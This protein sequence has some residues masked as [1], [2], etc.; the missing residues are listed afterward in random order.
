M[1]RR[2]DV[3]FIAFLVFSTVVLAE[4]RTITAEQLAVWLE[5]ED[6]PLVLDARGR[7]AHGERTISGALDVGTDPAGYLPDGRGGTVVLM[8]LEGNTVPDMRA[9]WIDR[10]EKWRHRVY[11]LV[12]G[13]DAWHDAGLPVEYPGNSYTVPGTVPFVIPR[14]ICEMNEPAGR[15][16]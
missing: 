14:G 15:F 2:V 3:A 11:V 8:M 13:P 6:P 9:A 16:E 1:P 10:L 5:S 12:G 4:T 7:D